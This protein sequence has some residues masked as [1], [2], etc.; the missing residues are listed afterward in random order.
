MML[1]L[2]RV[3]YSKRIIKPLIYS[4]KQLNGR[5]QVHYSHS[6]NIPYPTQKLSLFTRFTR[7]INIFSDIQSIEKE[8]LEIDQLEKVR[9]F[10]Y[11]L[12]NPINVNDELLKESS[13]I[14]TDSMNQHPIVQIYRSCQH[15]VSNSVR[16]NYLE[17]LE[18]MKNHLN[19]AMKELNSDSSSILLLNSSL[20]KD[21]SIELNKTSVFSLETRLRIH[22]YIE[23]LNHISVAIKEGDIKSESLSNEAILSSIRAFLLGSSKDR[24]T[25]K[26]FNL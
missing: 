5:I 15:I 24:L 18:L 14:T 8:K 13:D 11:S 19:I 20:N 25:G 3:L 22:L 9:D 1:I 2:S 21:D 26:Y 6:T 4:S 16:V 7:F 12:R 23:Y 17:V 10:L